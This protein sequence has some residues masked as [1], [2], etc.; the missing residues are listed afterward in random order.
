M[1]GEWLKMEHN[2]PEKPE[3]IAIASALS[4]SRFEVVGKLH[5]IWSWFDVHTTDGQVPDLTPAFV[6]LLVTHEGF[7][8][9]MSAVGWLLRVGGRTPALRGRVG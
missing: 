5:R 7:A 9:A 3:V 2:L 1:A 6:D 8:T 4:I